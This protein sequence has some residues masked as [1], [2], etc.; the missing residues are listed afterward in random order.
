LTSSATNVQ[1]GSVIRLTGT[2]SLP[3]T[4]TVTL[5]WARGD[6]GF[7]YEEDWPINNGVYERDVTFS[8]A[9][10]YQF[11]VVW[12]GD[13]TS[14][15][16]T[17]N[18]VTVTVTPADTITVTSPN[19]GETWIAGIYWQTQT[20][21]W[22]STG[23]PGDNVKIELL[24]GGVVDHIIIASTP[25]D[26]SWLGSGW[27]DAAQ[28]LGS[29]YKIR[30]TSTSDAAITDD[31]DGNF[32][33][34]APPGTLTVDSP[35]GGESW[36]AG[37]THTIRWHST[38]SPGD[39]V[40]INVLK[41]LAVQ[42]GLSNEPNDGECEWWIDQTWYTPGADYTIEVV[43]T[44]Y[45][46]VRDMSDQYFEITEYLGWAHVYSPNGGESWAAGST[47]R[48]S[49]FATGPNVGDNVKITLY[50]G[51][52]LIAIQTITAS[53]PN[54][55]FFD[56]P[57]PAGQQPSTSCIVKVSSIDG[58]VSDSSDNYFTITSP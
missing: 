48:I 45:N 5:Q 54:V 42:G 29:D 20:I 36:A 12:P 44:S 13:A 34:V 33:I 25:N 56:W 38:G 21:T 24:K 50:Y 27:I 14:Q 43:S 47:Q 26:G 17:S 7:I 19:G 37:S 49:W 41:N 31:S 8:Q 55:G 9:V 6:S 40:D 58:T 35:N 2:L 22:S 30:I 23:N 18:I 53:T 32:A 10:V 52:T 46:Y 15:A 28:T 1:F 57:I 51:T 4:G 16:A 39:Y 11:R 3:K